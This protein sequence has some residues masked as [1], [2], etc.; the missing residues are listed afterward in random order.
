MKIK[1]DKFIVFPCPHC[2]QELRIGSDMRGEDADCPKCGKA[3]VCPTAPAPLPPRK[4]NLAKGEFRCENCD[5]V[6]MP[7]KKPKGNILMTLFMCCLGIIPGLIY[8]IVK[9]GYR[10]ICPE[11]SYNFKTDVIR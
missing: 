9:S 7:I 5:F 6:G 3:L 2:G 4:P 10:Y 8:M 1:L 11:C